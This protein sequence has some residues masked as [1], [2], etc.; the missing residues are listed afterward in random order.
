MRE[1]FFASA[2]G[3]LSLYF[4]PVKYVPIELKVEYRHDLYNDSPIE[5]LVVGAVLHIGKD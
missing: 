4:V 3:G 2:C 1:D 5:G